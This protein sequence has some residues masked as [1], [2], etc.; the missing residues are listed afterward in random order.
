MTRY[1]AERDGYVPPRYVR[2]GEVFEYEGPA[3]S[4]ARRIE[5]SVEEE[6]KVSAPKKSVAKAKSEKAGG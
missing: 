2:G 3:P 5:D 4:W 6:A 1:I